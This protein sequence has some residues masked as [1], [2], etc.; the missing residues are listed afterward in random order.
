MNQA[1][2]MTKVALLG[3]LIKLIHLNIEMHSHR[4]SGIRKGRN[5]L[6]I[7][8]LRCV[9]PSQK[10]WPYCEHNYVFNFIVTI[11][12]TGSVAA[13]KFSLNIPVQ[14]T[15]FVDVT[16]C[17]DLLTRVNRSILNSNNNILFRTCTTLFIN[18]NTK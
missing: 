2:I 15:K 11:V 14:T 10:S 5:T 13:S 9:Q 17:S 18:S 8:S 4:H 3:Y 16:C 1:W 7:T 12:C 6:F